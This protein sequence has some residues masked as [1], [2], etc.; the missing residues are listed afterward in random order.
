MRF[1]LWVV[2]V[3]LALGPCTGSSGPPASRGP[4][5][6]STPGRTSAT[7]TVRTFVLEDGQTRLN[8][9]PPIADPGD[10]VI[11]DGMRL[12]VP[13]PGTHRGKSGKVWV[14]T[15]TNGSVSMGCLTDVFWGHLYWVMD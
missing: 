8:L 12:R 7:P 13:E 1:M 6:M 2:A 14:N 4:E 9:E 11:C 10:I 5:T 15:A 3:G